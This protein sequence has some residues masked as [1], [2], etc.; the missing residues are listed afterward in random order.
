MITSPFPKGISKSL[1]SLAFAAA[2]VLGTA[3]ATAQEWK[4]PRT[5][6]GKPDLNGVWM[7]AGRHNYNI[8]PHSAKAGMAMREGPLGPVPAKEVVKLGSIASVPASLGVVEGGAIPYKPEALK[9]R[10]EN[11]ANFLKSDPEV[12]CYLPGVP[13]ANYMPYAFQIFHNDDAL[14]FAYEYAGAV[15]NIL[16]EDPGPAPA[17]SWMGQAWLKWD[18]DTA[19]IT[20]TDMNGESWLDRAGNYIGY[21][22]V[23]TERY[24]LTGPNTMQYE[25][26]IENPDVFTQPWKIS[27][28]IYKMVGKDA[29]LQQFKCVEF[30]EE[31]MYGHLRK[32][33]LD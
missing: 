9:L 8:E 18:G 26:T 28:P 23:V 19:V 15:R 21:G 31:L 6:E 14:F 22:A 30:V 12:K 1:F 29:Q 24:T 20:V 25:A 13:R 3:Q 17:D 16:L 2:C 11:A 27:F 4:M 7:S 32:N 10:D 33:P 5:A